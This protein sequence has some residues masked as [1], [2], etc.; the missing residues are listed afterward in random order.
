MVQVCPRARTGASEQNMP[1]GMETKADMTTRG[2]QGPVG[3]SG[4]GAGPGPGD[5]GGEGRHSVIAVASF[6]VFLEFLERFLMLVLIDME[7]VAD[8]ALGRLRKKRSPSWRRI[9]RGHAQVRQ[10]RFHGY[11]RH[12]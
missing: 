7:Y 1:R 5:G 9:F 6:P 3:D 4:T 12:R 8:D 11:R 10:I 2:G